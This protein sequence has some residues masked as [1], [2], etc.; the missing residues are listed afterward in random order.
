MGCTIFPLKAD[1][2]LFARY[3]FADT[4]VV[5]LELLSLDRT[6]SPYFITPGRVLKR[7]LSRSV[8]PYVCVVFCVFNI[9]FY[10]SEILYNV[11]EKYTVAVYIF[12]VSTPKF[13]RGFSFSPSEIQLQPVTNTW[14]RI[15]RTNLF[16]FFAPFEDPRGRREQIMVN[17]FPSIED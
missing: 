1:F 13:C 2:Y 4:A 7:C 17:I 6:P 15:S 16:T 9:L 11:I 5:H 8:V 10:G 14:I 3:I 12:S